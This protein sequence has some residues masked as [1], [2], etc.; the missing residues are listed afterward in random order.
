MN[1]RIYSA[2]A[3][4]NRDSYIELEPYK[5]NDF[6][7]EAILGRIRSAYKEVRRSGIPPYRARRLVFNVMF[8]STFSDD[9][10]YAYKSQTKEA[11]IGC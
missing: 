11:P 9:H 10:T 1:Y 2:P 6:Y 5:D 4:K 7:H 8:A 3:G